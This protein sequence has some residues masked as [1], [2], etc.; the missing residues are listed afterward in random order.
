VYL[1]ALEKY[2][3][4]YISIKRVGCFILKSPI[5]SFLLYILVISMLTIYIIPNYNV[6]AIPAN[7]FSYMQINPYNGSSVTNNLED[8]TITF[9]RS[10]IIGDSELFNRIVI[11]DAQRNTIGRNVDITTNI[12]TIHIT[13]TLNINTTYTVNVPAGALYYSTYDSYTNLD[14]TTYFTTYNNMFANSSS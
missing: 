14:I 8:I 4:Y 7:N 9:G 5:N 10:I 11:M 2:F 6:S 1:R 12:L 3:A 13:G